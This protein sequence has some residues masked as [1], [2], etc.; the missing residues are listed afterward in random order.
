PLQ[1]FPQAYAGG[2]DHTYYQGPPGLL[3]PPGAFMAQP[4]SQGFYSEPPKTFQ[5]WDGPRP[6]GEPPKHTVFVVQQQ[7]QDDSADDSCLTT[8]S[9][10]LCCCFL[11]DML[12]SR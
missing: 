8:C 9:A 1:T 12:T 4:G 11:W 6:Y 10:A 3:R 5:Q 2:G 7:D